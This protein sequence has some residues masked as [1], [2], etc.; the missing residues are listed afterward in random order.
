MI[1]VAPDQLVDP[2]VDALLRC[3]LSA[4][5]LE[6]FLNAAADGDRAEAKVTRETGRAVNRRTVA[7]AVVR[8][9]RSR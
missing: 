2:A 4:R 5:A 7:V 8:T 1:K 9:D 6:R 3:G